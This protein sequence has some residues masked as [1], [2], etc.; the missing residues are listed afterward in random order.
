MR[1]L[2]LGACLSLAYSEQF[3]LGS[4]IASITEELGAVQLS[5]NSYR[6]GEASGRKL[7]VEALLKIVEKAS[8]LGDEAKKTLGQVST[9]LQGILTDLDADRA[10]EQPTLDAITGNVAAC[11]VQS[12]VDLEAEKK[13]ASDEAETNH[14]TCRSAEALL[15]DTMEADCQEVVDALGALS[16]LDCEISHAQVKTTGDDWLSAFAGIK[17]W[18]QTAE[19]ALGTKDD[20]CDVAETARSTKRN[21]CNDDQQVF[22]SH[23][24]TYT[25]FYSQRCTEQEGCY[26]GHVSTHNADVTRIFGEA[27]VRCE[28]AKM[29]AWVKCLVDYLI[30]NDPTS[31]DAMQASC[32]ATKNADYSSYNNTNPAVP[33][34]AVCNA[35]TF[36]PESN[37]WDTVYN[38]I[39]AVKSPAEDYSIVCDA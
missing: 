28:D 33:D 31:M 11:T 6:L 26:N 20:D 18:F 4:T 10:A 8:A 29:I 25:N 16:D 14:T 36:N 12:E 27:N 3:S 2:L 32:V 13:E 24:C 23:R 1:A 5:G 34:M 9:L 15:Y 7:G 37:D 39:D 35:D 21:E 30:A 17:T 38:H 22:E 19:T